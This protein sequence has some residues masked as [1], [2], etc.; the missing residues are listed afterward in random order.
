MWPWNKKEANWFKATDEIIN[1]TGKLNKREIKDISTI[2]ILN[3]LIF[4]VDQEPKTWGKIDNIILKKHPNVSIK[5]YGDSYEIWTDL[6]FLKH[7]KHLR[8]LNLGG[9]FRFLDLSFLSDCPNLEELIVGEP[10]NK[11]ISLSPID[12]LSKLSSL[13]ITSGFKDLG[14]IN[15][16]TS[17]EKL[18]LGGFNTKETAIISECTTIKTLNIRSGT[19]E[20]DVIR[21]MK[22]ITDLEIGDVRKLDNLDFISKLNNLEKLNLWWLS[23]VEAF[24]DFKNLVNL[25]SIYLENMNGLNDVSNLASATNLRLFRF[26]NAKKLQ[27]SHFH[28]LKDM[29]S[30]EDVRIGFGSNKK[31]KE[32]ENMLKE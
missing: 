2:P 28:F 9:Y 4:H 24:P 1:I 17:L 27:P 23:K 21:N 16:L 18:S 19:S 31:N 14:I 11:N 7:L 8:K 29:K 10:M 22:S 12:Q 6:G 30:V 15:Q 5:E 3:N 32:L 13:H 25:K 20:L 26:V